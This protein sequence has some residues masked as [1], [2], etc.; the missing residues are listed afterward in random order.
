MGAADEKTDGNINEAAIFIFSK[1]KK[2]KGRNIVITPT[3][4][5]SQSVV[6]LHILHCGN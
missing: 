4:Y 5:T 6:Q 2:K 3:L 1:N